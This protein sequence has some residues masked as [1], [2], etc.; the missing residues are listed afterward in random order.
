MKTR[1]HL[2]YE[3]GPYRLDVAE[4]RL[5]RGGNEI[6]LR[7]KLFDLLVV[8]VEHHGQML[9]KDELIQAVWP[10]L[11]IEENNLSVSINSLRRALKDDSY[12]E[13]VSRRGY[14]FVAE[15]KVSSGRGSAAKPSPAPSE[16]DP[17][18]GAMPLNSIF[19]VVRHTDDEF[20]AAMSRHDSIVLIKG[21]RQV[22]KTSLLARGL[23]RAR[24]AGATVVLTDFQHLAV[25]AFDSSEKL[26][27]TLAELIADQLDLPL[28]PHQAWNNFL[29]PGSNFE[30]YMRREALAKITTPLIW[31]VD[32]AD[33]LFNFD[34]ASEIFGLFRSWHNLRALD[35]TGP[36]DRLTVAF[37]YATEA[38]LFITDLNQSPFNVGTRLCLEDFTIDQI[39]E[40]NRRYGGPLRD[41]SEVVRFHELVGGHPYLTQRGLYAMVRSKISLAAVEAQSSDDEGVFGDHLRRMLVSVEHDPGLRKALSNALQEESELPLTIFYRLRSGGLFVGDSPG[42][43]RVR[44]K[45]Y[46][47]YLTSRLA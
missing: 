42:T 6:N 19:Y 33:R 32:E 5:V 17:P 9:T 36:W 14:R 46:E 24:E 28:L 40:L 43:A 23:Q 10:G 15:V 4:C 26:L 20:Y 12:I 34:Y 7:P 39:A 22:G 41:E 3:F 35:P 16:P 21:A 37:A 31:G 47:R 38:H 29:S 18:G 45:L 30:R 11:A 2:V 25:T 8:L 13:T 27:L 44:C 1:P